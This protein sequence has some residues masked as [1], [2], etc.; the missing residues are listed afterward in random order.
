VSEQLNTAQAVIIGQVERFLAYIH[1]NSVRTS[2]QSQ[3]IAGENLQEIVRLFDP[4]AGRYGYLPDE[5]HYPEVFFV[6][7]LCRYSGMTVLSNGE[8]GVTQY[9]YL[10]LSREPERRLVMLASAFVNDYPWAVLFPRGDLAAKI[11]KQRA[12]ALQFV[13]NLKPGTQTQI[14]K[15]AAGL[16]DRLQI[17]LDDKNPPYPGLILEWVL[18]HILITPLVRLG[19]M[20]LFSQ[21]GAGVEDIKSASSI[22]LTEAG[23]ALLTSREVRYA[24]AR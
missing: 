14:D 5:R 19:V 16:A 22:E 4:T 10:Y 13:L 6:D 7:T 21:D 11:A 20:R 9:G 15:F 18:R 3:L 24:G 12:D 23:K 17:D 8:L 2:R 1:S